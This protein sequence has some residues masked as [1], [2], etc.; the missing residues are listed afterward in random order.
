MT[1]LNICF[2]IFSQK[3]GFAILYKLY[4]IETFCM[5]CQIQVFEKK[6]ENLIN[7]SA[8][9]AWRVVKVEENTFTFTTL[10]V[11]SEDEKL[12]IFFLILPEKKALTFHAN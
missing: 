5:K 11:D 2:S 3:T 1:F 8:E 6:K 7:L 4:P 10:W 12:M 9:V